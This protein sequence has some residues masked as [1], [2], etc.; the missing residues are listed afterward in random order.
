MLKEGIGSGTLRGHW[1]DLHTLLFLNFITQHKE[2]VTFYDLKQIENLPASRV[3][4]KMKK[5]EEEGYLEK[6]EQQNVTGRPKF[7]FKISQMGLSLQ[8]TLKT[9]LLKVTNLLAAQY[10]K[11]TDFDI[12]SFLK[13]GTLILFKSPLQHILENSKLE[14]QEKLQCLQNMK[15]DH[16]EILKKID[17]NISNIKKEIGDQIHE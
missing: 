4:R 14:P 10:P 15:Q 16:E 11:H 1:H 8:D 3:Y 9:K 13:Q 12:E 2:G 17:I 6:T 5:L 7:V